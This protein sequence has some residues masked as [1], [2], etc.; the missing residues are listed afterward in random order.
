[1]Y[2]CEL[3]FWPTYACMSMH[4]YTRTHRIS[5]L[6]AHTKTFFKEWK[7]EMITKA[8]WKTLHGW[9]SKC[10]K[11]E[12]GGMA[13]TNVGKTCRQRQSKSLFWPSQAHS[14][15]LAYRSVWQYISG[16]GQ[17]VAMCQSRSRKLTHRAGEAAQV[18]QGLHVLSPTVC[19]KWA[20]ASNPSTHKVG[21][22]GQGIQGHP[23]LRREWD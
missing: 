20:C 17:S 2:P 3:V 18:E 5:K 22:E 11:A 16:A 8:G 15:C 14:R 10:A 4:A 21:A 7:K 13:L 19:K 9:P 6:K 12:E 1:M 23:Q